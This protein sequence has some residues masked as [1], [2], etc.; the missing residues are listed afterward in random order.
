MNFGK[1]PTYP[2]SETP[3]PVLEMHL[4]DFKGDVYGKDMEVA[5]HKFLRPEERFT[6]EESL[7]R[8]ISLDI[9]TAKRYHLLSNFKKPFTK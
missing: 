6:N 5:F 7:K 8:R 2:A 9:A 1:R 3:R 4:L